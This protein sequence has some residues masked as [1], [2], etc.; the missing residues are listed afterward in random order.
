VLVALVSRAGHL[1][2]KEEL[3]AE[4]WAGTFVEDANISYTISLVRR[5]LGEE[6]DPIETVPKVGYRFTIPVSLVT[7]VAPAI[8]PAAACQSMPWR[9]SR[10]VIAVVVM[11]LM[12]AGVWIALTSRIARNSVSEPIT[13]PV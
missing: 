8:P 3:L 2:T 13:V 6:A 11:L 5:A 9:V 4:V 12:G 7:A 1:V 10:T